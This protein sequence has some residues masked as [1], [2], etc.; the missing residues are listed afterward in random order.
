M[1]KQAFGYDVLGQTQTCDWFNRFKIDR[2]SADEDE[3]SG[4]TSFGTTLEKVENVREV[5][6]EDRLW[7]IGWRLKYCGTSYGT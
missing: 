2:K 7:T 1:L 6:Q 4:R 5:I 3:S